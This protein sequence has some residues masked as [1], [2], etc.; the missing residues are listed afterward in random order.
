MCR[1]NCPGTAIDGDWRNRSSF[2]NVWRGLFTRIEIQM[3]GDGL[4]PLSLDPRRE[5]MEQR[6]LAGLARGVRPSVGVMLGGG[7]DDGDQRDGHGDEHGNHYDDDA[8]V[9]P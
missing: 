4:H 6:F 2:C 5:E 1:G 7:D 3:L 8:G 9:N